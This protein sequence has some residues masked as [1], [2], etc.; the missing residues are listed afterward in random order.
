MASD[1]LDRPHCTVAEARSQRNLLYYFM[2]TFAFANTSFIGIFNLWAFDLLKE[3][4]AIQGPLIPS[5]AYVA[6]LVEP[7]TSKLLFAIMAVAGLNVF[8]GRSGS[9]RCL[10][11]THHRLTLGAM[12]GFLM[13][14][15]ELYIKLLNAS[16]GTFTPFFWE[17]P[18]FTPGVLPP[19]LLHTFNGALIVGTYL[20]VVN[21]VEI[22]V[23][24]AVFARP[25][26]AAMTVATCIHFV[27]N[28]WWIRQDWF[29]DWWVQT[30]DAWVTLSTT[31]FTQNGLE[32][33]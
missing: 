20:T 14:L 15:G 27:W 9:Y 29:W 1:V 7:W 2:L 30:Y 13:G 24:E 32:I 6:A 25:T 10:D 21:D 22:G 11:F 26:L 18:E 33:P 12:G 16:Q 23:I 19:V 4:L 5:N 8:V 3:F 31:Y 28:T 17:H